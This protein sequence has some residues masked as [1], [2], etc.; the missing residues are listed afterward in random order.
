VIAD[1]IQHVHDSVKEGTHGD[2]WRR[3]CLSEMVVSMVD[4]EKR[5]AR[6]GHAHQVPRLRRRVDRALKDLPR[7]SN[8]H[9]HLP[10]PESS[11]DRHRD[12][13]PLIEIVGRMNPRRR[14]D[15]YSPKSP[16]QRLRVGI[17][18]LATCRPGRRRC[19][20]LMYAPRVHQGADELVRVASHLSVKIR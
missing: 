14:A 6:C 3:R 4:V 12:V 19:L 16:A 8:R 18:D 7:S 10:R 1:A 11:H 20:A 2:P 5:L 15:Q 13:L 17:P 9:D